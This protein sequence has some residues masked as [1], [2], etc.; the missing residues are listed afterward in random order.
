MGIMLKLTIPSPENERP[1]TSP[2]GSV[3][4]TFAEISIPRMPKLEIPSATPRVV[5]SKALPAAKSMPLSTSTPDE[6]GMNRSNTP[7]PYS[8]A[9][10]TDRNLRAPVAEKSYPTATSGS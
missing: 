1:V 3:G 8:N 10:S 6:S 2:R 4:S 5:R 7:S 9:T